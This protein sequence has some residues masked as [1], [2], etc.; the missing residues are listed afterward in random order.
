MLPLDDELLDEPLELELPLWLCDDAGFVRTS[1]SVIPC[2]VLGSGV[3]AL[4]LKS[5]ASS[6]VGRSPGCTVPRF[7]TVPLDALA[8]ASTALPASTALRKASAPALLAKSTRVA[9]ASAGMVKDDLL[10]P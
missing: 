9:T 2:L 10:L 6:S 5:A 7:F 8:A 1:T 4:V 3:K